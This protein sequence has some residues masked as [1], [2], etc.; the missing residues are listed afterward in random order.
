MLFFPPV[1]EL[2]IKGSEKRIP[3]ISNTCAIFQSH[4]HNFAP[5][6]TTMSRL[7]H[8]G[9]NGNKEE[10]P[11]PLN[12]TKHV[13]DVIEWNSTGTFTIAA[14]LVDLKYQIYNVCCVS[15]KCH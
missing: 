7:Q 9:T 10:V 2:Y 6:I 5:I 11:P 3:F 14:K 15:S 12:K 1:S 4:S 8:G 13:R